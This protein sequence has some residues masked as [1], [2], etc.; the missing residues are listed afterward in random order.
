MNIRYAAKVELT[1]PLC[2]SGP[3][4]CISAQQMGWR[5]VACW[6][7]LLVR[8]VQL[9]VLEACSGLLLQLLAVCSAMRSCIM[10]AWWLAVLY[11]PGLCPWVVCGPCCHFC[12]GGSQL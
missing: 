12:G 4:G 10:G 1:V 7:G 8:S 5:M 6:Q 2:L 11:S 9:V 3:A